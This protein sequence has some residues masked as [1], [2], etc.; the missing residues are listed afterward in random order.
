VDNTLLN[1]KCC[2]DLGKVSV[3]AKVKI[4]GQ[5]AGGVWT[6]PYRVNVTPYLKQGENTLEIEAVNTW[7]NRIIGD[8]NLP[9]EQRK[10][11]PNYNSWQA[12]SP[13]QASGLTGPVE[14]VAMENQ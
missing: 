11:R 13:L 7:V 1:K 14:I 12:D 9:D 4:N 5:Y 2:L 8:L 6:A 10:V 3:M